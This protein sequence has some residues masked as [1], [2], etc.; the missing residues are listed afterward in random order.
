MSLGQR[1]RALDARLQAGPTLPPRTDDE[2]T[3]TACGETFRGRYCPRCGQ[4]AQRSHFTVRGAL[5]SLLDL[6]GFGSRSIFRTV[7]QLYY[8]PGYL[9]ADY[10]RGRQKLYFPP[11]QLLVTSAIIYLAAVHLAGLDP[12]F[13]QFRADNME[14]LA[15]Y[16]DTPRK[17]R[18]MDVIMRY[19]FDIPVWIHEHVEVWLLLYC[20]FSIF[21]TWTIF[22][23]PV[24]H[25]Q[26]GPRPYYNL[27][28]TFYAQLYIA[29][30]MLLLS[31]PCVLLSG[32]RLDLDES[33]IYP[34]NV[35]M[36]IAIPLLSFTYMQ[37]YRLGPWGALWRTVLTTLL[38]FGIFVVL[39]IIAIV[40]IVGYLILTA[41][42]PA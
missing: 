38:I 26:P 35:P 6:W 32:Q 21:V 19:F 4:D 12:D 1:L 20:I 27:V 9:I 14:M 11:F 37:L 29:S 42:V 40:I 10:L 16:D 28:E 36:W 18:V 34:W 39:L 25:S 5:L 31:V 15:E 7:A 23:C 13:E 3:C 8:R 33:E 2:Q 24:R 17:H 22:S 41:R 30:Q